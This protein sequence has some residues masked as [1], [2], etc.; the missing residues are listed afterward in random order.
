[1][2]I[3]E[4]EGPTLIQV[5]APWCAHCRSMSGDIRALGD[6]F[7]G[8]VD[9]VTVDASTSRETATTLEVKG[10][11]TLIGVAQGTEVFRHTGSRTRQQLAAMFEALETGNSLQTERTGDAGLAIG[12]GSILALLGAVAGPAWDLVSIGTAVLG[13]GLMRALR[14]RNA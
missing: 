5:T 14:A 3:G 11:P 9:L 10:T 13:F 6:E 2:D 12:A 1:M 8:R 4:I 7:E